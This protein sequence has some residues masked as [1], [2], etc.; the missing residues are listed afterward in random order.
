LKWWEK[1]KTDLSRFKG[2]IVTNAPAL[3]EAEVNWLFTMRRR[4]AG[5]GQGVLGWNGNT[6]ASAINL[7]LILGAE[8]VFLLG[9]DMKLGENKKPNWHEHRVE[10]AAES[11]YERFLKGFDDVAIDLKTKFPNRKVINITDDSDLN[12]FPKISLAEHF[13]VE[14]ASGS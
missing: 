14:V 9:F 7:A 12:C 5:L 10:S 4:P 8:R 1:Y 13:G 2:L 6:G 11:V 3:Y